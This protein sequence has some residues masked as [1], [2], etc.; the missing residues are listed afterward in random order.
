[1]KEGA[2]FLT[3]LAKS[4]RMFF[5]AARGCT[6]RHAEICAWLLDPLA[7]WGRAA[8]G[9]G[10]FEQAAKGYARY[11]MHV[12]LAQRT[13]EKEGR[14]T[15]DRL[16]DIIEKVYENESYMT[17]YMW[18]AVLIYAFWES[19]VNHLMLFRGDFIRSLPPTPEVLELAC[20]HGAM[21]LLACEERRD[22]ELV[23]LDIGPAAIRIARDLARV[24]GHEGRAQFFLGDVLA[25]GSLANGREF[26]GVMAA[27]IAEHLVD[28]RPLFRSVADALKTNGLAFVSTALE[29]PQCDHVFEF[30]RES[31]LVSLAEEA[32]LRV[33]RLVSDGGAVPPGMRFRPRALAMILTK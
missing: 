32:G 31:E 2:Q 25:T 23:G 16:P 22:L 19:M 13:Y 12:S 21:G 26:D 24:S 9:E 7:R 1:M 4:A 27:M 20:G 3:A 18:A 6:E 29:S 11:C 15:P 10:V 17:P 14:Y 8:Y 30:H 28:P 5:P 33:T